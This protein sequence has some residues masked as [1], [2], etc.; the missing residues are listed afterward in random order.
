MHD[1]DNNLR[2]TDEQASA[3]ELKALHKTISKVTEDLDRLSWNTVVSAMMIGVNDLTDLKSS[4]RSILQPLVVLLS[5]YAPHL[6]EELWERLQG[7]GS[8]MDKPW[9][10]W[11]EQYLV[12]ANFTYPVSFNGKVRFKVDL[13]ADM[14]AADVEK[15]VMDNEKTPQYLE[16]KAPKKVIVVQGRIVNIVL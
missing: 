7:E 2:V 4:K 8:V 1:Q 15:A 12:E 3:D 16:G 14:N 6:A 11:E 13:P 5:P 10:K 9:P